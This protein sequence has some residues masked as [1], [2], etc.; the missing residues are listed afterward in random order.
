MSRDPVDLL[1]RLHARNVAVSV[2]E[3]VPA[4]QRLKAFP[5]VETRDQ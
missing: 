4:Y 2:F 1:A 5:S 3:S